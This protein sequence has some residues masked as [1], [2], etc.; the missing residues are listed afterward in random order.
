MLAII[1]YFFLSVVFILLAQ[2]VYKSPIKSDAAFSLIGAGGV[3]IGGIAGALY[4]FVQYNESL[5]HYN[6]L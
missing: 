1:I 3:I 6:G 5:L 4:P 2:R